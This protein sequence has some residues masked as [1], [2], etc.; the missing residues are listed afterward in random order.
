MSKTVKIP[1]LPLCDICANGTTQAHFDAKT[2]AGPWAFLCWHHWAEL[3]DMVLGTGHGQ[4]LSTFDATSS[5]VAG[6]LAMAREIAAR[7]Q[8]AKAP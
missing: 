3:T 1:H 2:T 6:K 8:E 7:H 4:I 5:E